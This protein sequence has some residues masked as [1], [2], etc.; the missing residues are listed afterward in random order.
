[1]A[2]E[3]SVV[4][5]IYN[6]IAILD[7]AVRA[8]CAKLDHLGLSYEILLSQNGSSD[9]TIELAN[10]LAKEFSAL[11][12]LHHDEPNYGKALRSGIAAATGTYIVCDEI[13]LGHIEFYTEALELLRAGADFVVGSKRHPDSLDERPWIRRRGTQVINGLLALSLGFKG[14]DTHGLKAFNRKR[15]VPVVDSCIVEHDLF[16]S[17]LVIRAARAECDVREIPLRLHEIRPPSIGLAQRVPRVLSNL[18]K[19][20][21]VIRF[22]G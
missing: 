12:V 18:L 20:V 22:K 21:Y 7:T 13:D 19:L 10:A 6:E 8:L 16:A 5:P 1:M 17:E 15:L 2:V 9:G 14:S 11:Q 4:I 3:C